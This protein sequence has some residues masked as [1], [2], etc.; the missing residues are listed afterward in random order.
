M[1]LQGFGIEFA[2]FPLNPAWAFGFGVADD[3]AR[4]CDGEMGDAAE[5]EEAHCGVEV[6]ALGLVGGG[7]GEHE[8]CDPAGSGIFWWVCGS[9]HDFAECGDIA[10]QLIPGADFGCQRASDEAGDDGPIDIIE[11]FAASFGVAHVS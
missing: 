5:F 8:R 11:P 6:L 3:H 10:A 7:F 1:L 2:A 4:A 9:S